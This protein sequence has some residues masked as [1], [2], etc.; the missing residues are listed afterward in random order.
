MPAAVIGTSSCESRPASPIR[1]V[2]LIVNPRSGRGRA[3][4]MAGE[5]VEALRGAGLAVQRVDLGTPEAARLVA[6]GADVE[7]S[8]AGVAA[9]GEGGSVAAVVVGGDGTVHSC[10]G[11]LARA[12][13]AVYHVP[14]GTENLFARQFGMR[15]AAGAVVEALRRGRT[16]AVD[17]GECAAADSVRS[18]SEDGGGARDAAPPR[19]FLVV[20]SVGFDAGVIHRLAA[21]RRGAISHWSYVGP[22]ARELMQHRAPVFSIDVDGR[23]VVEGVRG[24]AIVANCRQYAM[25]IDPAARAEMN[26]GVLDLVFFPARWLMSVS[27]WAVLARLRL[28]H[29]R[30]ALVTARGREIHVKA[31]GGRAVLQLDGEAVGRADATE[32]A[33]RFTIR[34]SAL[35]VLA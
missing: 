32:G 33:W 10:A 7:E 24:V 35:Q 19:A 26:D 28:H 17:V 18:E 22:I 31:T 15:A 27:A 4:R 12:G 23:R 14:T 13:I 21:A 34:P 16:M 1:S 25:R 11:L 30:S 2:L 3:G 5:L 29:R 9:L 6:A 8:G 20:G